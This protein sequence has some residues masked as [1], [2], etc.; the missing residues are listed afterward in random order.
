MTVA[1]DAWALAL[2]NLPVSEGLRLRETAE[3]RYLPATDPNRFHKLCGIRDLDAFLAGESARVPRVSLADSRR[4]GSAGIPTEEFTLNDQGL[5][6]LTRLFELY[7]GGAT[8]VLSEMNEVH[9][10]LAR[11]CRGLERIF[12]HPVQCNIY[13]TPPNA[14]GFR[15]HY[16]THDV[17]ILQVQGEKL[18]RYWPTIPLPFANNRTPWQ[19]QPLPAEEPRTQMMRPGDVLYVPRGGLHDAASQGA[20]SSL[21]LTIGLLDISWGD[22]LRAALDVMEV[23][24]PSLRES[25]P[26]WRLAEGGMSDAIVRDAAQRLTT[27]GNMSVMEMMAQQLLSTLATERMPML[28]RGLIGP[29]VTPTDRLY[30]SDTMHH[31]VVPHPDGTADLRWSGESITLTAEE[32]GWL[33]RIDEGASARDLGGEAALAF[34]QRLA[35]LGLLTVQP[36][37]AMKAAE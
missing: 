24:N 11:F 14:Q 2:G 10:P 31:V 3:I 27:L 34:C 23:Q 28:S 33:A 26:T 15:T 37:S 35:S 6:D 8:L 1:S 16:D 19:N 7:D 5:V 18:W 25:F 17:L 12:L 21:H 9:P 20:Q 22:A 29:V 30:L 4:Q 32:L 36:V 13:L